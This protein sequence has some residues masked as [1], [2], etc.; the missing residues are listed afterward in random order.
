MLLLDLVPGKSIV[1]IDSDNSK[2]IGSIQ[3]SRHCKIEDKIKIVFDFDK[4]IRILRKE[5]LDKP[6]V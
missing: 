5:L 1:F 2:I 3:I 6:Q 4:N